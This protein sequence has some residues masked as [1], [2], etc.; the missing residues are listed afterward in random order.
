MTEVL[1]EIEVAVT[2]TPR[3]TLS[4]FRRQSSLEMSRSTLWRALHEDV[5]ARCFKPVRA[6]RLT[7]ENRLAQAPAWTSAQA[8]VCDL[9]S[10][11]RKSISVWGPCLCFAS[12]SLLFFSFRLF[13]LSPSLSLPLSLP[14]SPR[15]SSSSSSSPSSSPS[16]FFTYYH[17]SS[18]PLF[19][20]PLFYR[21]FCTPYQTRIIMFLKL[22]MQFS[23]RLSLRWTRKRSKIRASIQEAISDFS[24]FWTILVPK[25]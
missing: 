21:C 6:P 15:S 5:Q 1:A 11:S 7:A 25:V 12:P 4:V 10:G 22:F 20:F 2:E 23:C 8:T 24:T 18:S 13:S 14:P 16:H 19:N 9:E 3:Q 17:H